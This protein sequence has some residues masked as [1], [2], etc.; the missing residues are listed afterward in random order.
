MKQI[1]C[2]QCQK[3]WF[4]ARHCRITHFTTI[5]VR[6]HIFASGYY[7][8]RISYLAMSNPQC[9]FP[10]IL[11][12]YI[13]WS[14]LSPEGCKVTNLLQE[15]YCLAFWQTFSQKKVKGLVK[16][17]KTCHTWLAYSFRESQKPCSMHVSVTAVL[18]PS[19]NIIPVSSG[20]GGRLGE[21]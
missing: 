19:L 9:Q 21:V 6:C 18:F 1:I 2:A 20:R 4:S 12:R 5:T 15:N 8:V 16:Q 11:D 7:T 14:V 13:V 17:K 10:P 3:K